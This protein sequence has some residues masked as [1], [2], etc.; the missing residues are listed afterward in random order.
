MDLQVYLEAPMLN[1]CKSRG[2][3]LNTVEVQTPVWIF[4]ALF[5]NKSFVCLF[6]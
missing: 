5:F 4:E 3:F 6:V 2:L 1:M